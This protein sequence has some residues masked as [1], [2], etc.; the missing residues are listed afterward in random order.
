MP[1][2]E[3]EG[4]TLYYEDEGEGYPL[5]LVHGFGSS[6]QDWELQFKAFSGRYR[7]IAPD[8]RGFGRSQRKEPMSIERLAS[9]ILGLLDQ[10][11]IGRF[12]LLGF[13]LGGAVAFQLV[14]V[15]QERVDRLVLVNTLPNFMPKTL[16]KRMEVWL[17]KVVVRFIGMG[18]MA[19][20][21]AGR[22]FPDEGQ[23]ELRDVFIERY[24][25][26]DKLSYLAILESAPRWSVEELLP[27]FAMPTLLI[28]AEHDYANIL[29]EKE[30]RAF[31]AK[32]PDARM[33]V[34]EGSRHA[35]PIDR[36][37]TFNRLVED[38]LTDGSQ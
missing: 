19:N 3:I 8:L 35:T 9:D 6:S 30:K 20:L 10:L 13:S 2:V 29:P 38:F 27:T 14:S 18:T 12:H 26:N 21:I 24:S 5:V 33:V 34:V 4:C 22:L 7:V 37:D 15:A 32:M 23:E 28:S 1:T 25:R 31:V 16:R 17:R 36:P 11:G